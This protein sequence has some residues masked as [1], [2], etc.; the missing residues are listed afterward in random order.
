M[1]LDRFKDEKV[2]EKLTESDKYFLKNKAI[3]YINN[4]TITFP[5]CWNISRNLSL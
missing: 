3:G 5:L 4:A 1:E 2:I